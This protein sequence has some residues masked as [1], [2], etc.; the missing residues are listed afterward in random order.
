MTRWRVRSLAVVLVFSALA[1]LAPP[2][3]PAS[4]AQEREPA[5]AKAGD[6]EL[7]YRMDLVKRMSPEQQTRLR[8]ALRRLRSL[9]EAERR[10]LREKARRVGADRLVGV[11]GRDVARL[12]RKHRDFRAR[13][14]Q[15]VRMLGGDERFRR[16]SE[17][18]R[19]YLESEATRSFHRYLRNSFL[20]LLTPAEMR[21]FESL[22]A[23]ERRA[24]SRA[25][26][27][28]IAAEVLAE[29]TEEERAHYDA[30]DVRAR[31]R[32]MQTWMKSRR[33]RVIIDWVPLFDR[34]T[35]TPFLALPA[36]ERAE[37]AAKWR[38]RRR[39]YDVGRMIR[40]SV[41]LDR[42]ARRQ[43][44]SLGPES[45]ASLR[46]VVESSSGQAPGERR[47][48]IQREIRRLYTQAAMDNTL[49]RAERPGRGERSERQDR[50]ERPDRSPR[51]GRGRSRR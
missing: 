35:V 28:R 20:G 48:T 30:L 51:G 14:E 9:P 2:G 45:L 25:S 21:E 5:V 50:R 39:W 3:V 43:L 46:Q 42:D 40:K 47:V 29:R 1:A 27:E 17:D 37:R 4:V 19:G 31:R 41:R 38:E 7:S 24:R 11:A 23:E 15:I 16:L 32:Q 34:G 8:E 22:P 13:R 18:E 33:E 44:H 10:R 26:L 36:D 12:H 49:R 6:A